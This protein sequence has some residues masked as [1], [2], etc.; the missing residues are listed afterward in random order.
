M[1]TPGRRQP[2]SPGDEPLDLHLREALRQA[3][4]HHLAPPSPL[5][6]RIQAAAHAAVRRP[7]PPA[8]SG[9][10]AWLRR[11][12]AATASPRPLWAGATAALLVSVLT[13]SMWKDEPVPPAVDREVGRPAPAAPAAPPI[14]SPSPIRPDA[15]TGSAGGRT[16]DA[17]PGPVPATPPNPAAGPPAQGQPREA[18]QAM[19]A[20]VAKAKPDAQGRAQA[21]TAEPTIAAAKDEAIAPPRAAPP[22]V[23][24]GQPRLAAGNAEPQAAAKPQASAESAVA[25]AGPPAGSAGPPAAALSLA[26]DGPASSPTLATGR[27]AARP[28]M[29]SPAAA[30]PPA[31]APKVPTSDVMESMRLSKRASVPEP[32][33]A[34]PAAPAPI[35]APATAAAPPT[36]RLPVAQ[37]TPATSPMPP[38][39]AIGSPPPSW[40]A[41]VSASR[42]SADPADAAWLLTPSQAQLIERLGRDTAGWRRDVGPLPEASTASRIMLWRHAQGIPAQLRLEATGVRWV[43]P[44]GRHWV[45]PLTAAQRA[46]VA[47]LF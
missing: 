39:A 27:L 20:P 14:A 38:T 25:P 7:E 16:P 37:P 29:V 45:M 40:A 31:T 19:P 26:P 32:A 44:D 12:W 33:P 17:A 46:E 9:W 8:A 13:V 22:E 2:D 6:Q 28:P 21:P 3:P 24:R 4:D 42:R 34:S 47:T 11:A 30:P 18:V 35:P 1:T 5:S 10:Q 23:A 43:E 15:G 36:P 41:W